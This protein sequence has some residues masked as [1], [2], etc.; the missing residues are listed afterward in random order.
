MGKS[1]KI[2]RYN[3]ISIRL[4]DEERSQLDSLIE[5]KFNSVS[6]FMRQALEYYATHDGNA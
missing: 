1:I 5:Q 2:T 3:V 6:D 4:S